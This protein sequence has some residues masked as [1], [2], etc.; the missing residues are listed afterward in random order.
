MYIEDVAGDSLRRFLSVQS[1][2]GTEFRSF[3]GEV[4]F[5][6]GFDVENYF[7]V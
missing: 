3:N 7:A 5:T 6:I 2:M 1:K 4:F